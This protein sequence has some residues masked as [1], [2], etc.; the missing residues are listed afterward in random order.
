MA[1]QPDRNLQRRARSMPQML[2]DDIRMQL[3]AGELVP[4]QPLPPEKELLATYGVS[5]PTL[6]EAMRI[7]EA[8]SLVETVRGMNGGAIVR[9]PD[10]FVVL[11]QAAVFLQLEGATFADV[12]AAR[13]VLEI[14]A[15]RSLAE[16]GRG[17]DVAALREIIGEGRRRADGGADAF[18]Q[19][20]GCFHRKL[21]HLS[22]NKTM[23]FFVDVLTG[24][25]DATYNRKVASLEPGP[26]EA[27]ILKAL[28]SWD[29]LTDLIEKRDADRAQAHWTR[30]LA[31][32]GG[33]LKAQDRPLA[34]EVLPQPNGYNPR[35][36][37]AS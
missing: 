33:N 32:V 1:T 36:T 11:R 24:L 22:R 25:T 26:R 31:T 18:G 2:A 13:A 19:V 9:A 34:A 29:K 8:E 20:A 17:T 37:P 30:H 27:Q 15:V 6:R 21:V 14:S 4:G 5:R 12:Y 23:S 35:A 7:L 28:R 16:R 3:V 10:P